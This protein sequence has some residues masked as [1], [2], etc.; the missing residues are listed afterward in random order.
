MSTLQ[1]LFSTLPFFQLAVIIVASQLC[2]ALLARWGQS[3]VIG[4]I[5]VGILLG[6]CLLLALGAQWH[7]AVFPAAIRLG[8]ETLGNIGLV[9]L[10][11]QIGLRFDN[12]H[13]SNQKI[14]FSALSVAA[15]GVILA[16]ALGAMVGLLSHGALAPAQPRL[17]YVLFCGIALSITALPVLVRIISDLGLEHSLAGTV[18]IA[19]AAITDIIGWVLLTL[20]VALSS[21][22]SS[23]FG[24]LRQLSFIVLFLVLARWGL[25]PLLHALTRLLATRSAA[26]AADMSMALMLATAL[27]FGWITT[28]IGLHS[29]LGGLIAGWLLREQRQHWHRHMEGFVNIGLVPF[30]FAATGLKMDLGALAPLDSWLWLLAFFAAAVLGKTAGCYLAGRLAGLSVEVSR[31][32]AVLMNTRGL[33][34]IIVLSVGLDM[35]LISQSAFFLLLMVAIATTLM[36][37]PLLR[38][39]ARIEA[40]PS[41][42]AK[43]KLQTSDR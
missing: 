9:L 38:R 27:L 34:E 13:L 15:G 37:T 33:I 30:Y 6:P 19:A 43:G 36:T 10:M 7:A 16:F 26:P 28:L 25:R 32:V 11:F 2:G 14:G 42:L 39:L 12:S 8:I 17:G 4:E 5:C 1:Q 3:R 24:V 21:S 41:V 40:L 22:D 18:G 35:G 20:I 23:L 31:S 29:A